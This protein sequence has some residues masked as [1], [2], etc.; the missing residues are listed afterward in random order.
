MSARLSQKLCK[1]LL[2]ISWKRV[3]GTKGFDWRVIGCHP[4]VRCYAQCNACAKKVCGFQAMCR[5]AKCSRP[6]A[7]QPPV[8][9]MSRYFTLRVCCAK[10]PTC[11]W[12][13]SC[14]SSI[15]NTASTSLLQSVSHRREPPQWKAFFSAWEIP[16]WIYQLWLIKR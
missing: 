7:T 3:S 10:K 8:D 2:D 13:F 6:S 12:H 9:Q 4:Q 15:T 16:S 11:L 14:R 5:H 1:A